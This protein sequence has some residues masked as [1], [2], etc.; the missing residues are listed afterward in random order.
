MTVVFSNPDAQPVN[1]SFTAAGVSDGAIPRIDRGFNVSASG[2]FVATIR[3]ERSF[4]KEVTWFVCSSD[5]AGTAASWTA[6]FSV[7]VEEPEPGVVYRLNCP[8]YTSGTVA[9]RISQ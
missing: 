3:L 6:P 2:A 4:D 7:V 5:S 9:Y 1:G 8:T